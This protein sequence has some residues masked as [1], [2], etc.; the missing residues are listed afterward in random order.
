MSYSSFGVLLTWAPDWQLRWMSFAFTGGRVVTIYQAT[1][2]ANP[3]LRYTTFF[4][5]DTN[6]WTAWEPAGG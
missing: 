2:I 6:S 1:N 5:P 3:A 4:D